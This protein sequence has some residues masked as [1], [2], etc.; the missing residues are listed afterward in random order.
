MVGAG[1][2]GTGFDTPRSKRVLTHA[3]AY[4]RH[5]RVEL[6]GIVD[7]QAA[8]A[9]KAAKAW[10]CEAFTD[11]E[12]A[13]EHVRPELVS[14]CTPNDT[15]EAVLRAIANGKY[16]PRL[17]ICEKPLAPDPARAKKIAMLYR[18]RRIALLVDHTRRFDP[19]VVAT[20]AAFDR[21]EYGKA[22]FGWATYSRGILHSGPHII[23]LARYFFGEV[24][25]MKSL[26]ARE[27][28]NPGDK[29]VGAF[30]TME[31]CPQFFLMPGDARK[32]EYFQFDLTCEKGRISFFDLG[33]RMSRQRVI[34][35]PVYKGYKILSKP[36]IKQT[37]FSVAMQELINQAVDVLDGKA[38]PRCDG[39]DAARTQEVCWKLLKNSPR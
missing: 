36:L 37:G 28:G 29:S 32:Y 27:D 18:K 25:S 21:G 35:D 15:H 9:H 20:K 11:L 2:I 22:L 30:L 4:L 19:E 33:F 5:P 38:K 31:R 34:D 8:S 14:V 24:T 17:V 1:R 3:H 10:S 23:D 16:R 13:L 6:K 12:I 7:T 39:M 26:F